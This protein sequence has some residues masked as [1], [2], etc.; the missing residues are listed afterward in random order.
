MGNTIDERVVSMRFDNQQFEKN[1]QISLGTLSKLKEA[2]RFDKIDMSGIS[3][4]IQAITDKVTGMGGIWD[5]A[6]NRISNKVVDTASQISR[7]FVFNPPTDGFKEYELKMNSLKVIMESSHE[8]LETVNKY[9]NEL[10]TYSDKTIYSFSDMTSSIGKFTNAGVDLDTAVKAIQ[11]IANEAALAGANTNEASRAMYNFAQALSAGSVKLIDWKSI[12]NANMA[13]KDFKE[14]LIK[15]A[16]ELGTLKKSGDDYIST[17]TN[18]QGKTSEAFNATKGFNDSLASQW[19]TTEVL[20]KTLGRYADEN[21]EI[22][23]RA[24]KAATEV[25]TFSAMMDALKEAVGSGW[26]QTWE[27]LFGNME[28]ATE[29]WTG[30]NDVLSDFIGK[31]SDARNNMLQGWKDMGGRA[32][33]IEGISNSFKILGNV[34]K[35]LKDAIT[36][37]FPPVTG[38]NLADISAKFA[39]FTAKVEKA[40]RFFPM[41]FFDDKTKEDSGLFG[42]AVDAVTSAAP[43]ATKAVDDTKKATKDLAKEVSNTS[44]ENSKSAEKT[45]KDFEK[46]REVV[47]GVVNGDYGN[48]SARVDALKKA[49]F[50]PEY[51]QKYV[52][53]LHELSGGTW[54]LSDKML[55]SVEKSIGGV[56]KTSEAT[57][58]AAD[59]VKKEL[60]EEE[61]AAQKYNE[62]LKASQKTVDEWIKK[63]GEINKE[64]NLLT[65]ILASAMSGVIEI[66]KSGAKIVGAFGAAWRDSFS[67]ITI[68]VESVQAVAKAF[69]DFSNKMKLSDSALQSFYNIFK[70]FFSVFKLVRDSVI[71]FAISALPTV[72]NV[73]SSIITTVSHIIQVGGTLLSVVVD[74][75]Q[76]TQ[77]IQTIVSALSAALRAVGNVIS[78]VAK[79]LDYFV[80]KIAAAI[81]FV[82][83]Y[84]RETGLLEAVGSRIAQIF[85]NIGNKFDELKGKLSEKLG[86]KNFDELKTKLDGIFDSIKNK[87]LPWFFKLTDALRDFSNGANPLA[88]LFGKKSDGAS[89]GTFFSADDFAKDKSVLE[90]AGDSIGYSIGVLKDTIKEKLHPNKDENG[91]VI[92]SLVPIDKERL[93]WYKALDFFAN[94]KTQLGN[95]LQSLHDI[96]VPGHRNEDG[97]FIRELVPIDKEK[98]ALGRVM[99]FLESAKATLTT[100]VSSLKEIIFGKRNEKGELIKNLFP[101]DKEG[102]ALQKVLGFL[103]KAAGLLS[104]GLGKAISGLTTIMSKFGEKQTSAFGKGMASAG[105]ALQ[106]FGQKF[107]GLKAPTADASSIADKLKTLFGILKDSVLPKVGGLFVGAA[108][109]IGNFIKSLNAQKVLSMAF[110]IKFLLGIIQG[111]KLKKALTGTITSIGGFFDGLSNALPGKKEE[112]KTTSMLKIAV[113]IA[114]VAKSISMIAD[115]PEDRLWSSVG[116]IAAIAAVLAGLSIALLK[117][118]AAEGSD[119][120]GAT[121]VIVAMGVAM[122]LIASSIA[123]IA[124]FKPQELEAA[125]FAVFMVIGTLTGAVAALNKVGK[126][127]PATVAGPIAF[128]IALKLL[129]KTISF[130]GK[131]P[132]DVFKKGEKNIRKIGLE[133]LIAM[134]VIGHGHYNAAAVA[135]P[136]AFALAVLALV[137]V[138]ALVG[139]IPV[140]LLIK[141]LIVV[142][143]LS[144]VLTSAMK[145]LKGIKDPGVAAAPLFLALGILALAF[146]VVKLGLVDTGAIIKGFIVVGLLGAMLVGFTKLINYAI[147]DGTIDKSIIITLIA[148]AGSILVLGLAMALLGKLELGQL[149]KGIV[150]VGLLGAII[151]AIM[152]FFATFSDG[153]H[154]DKSVV[155]AMIAVVGSILVLGITAVMLSLIP[156]PKLFKAVVAIGLLGAVL[157]ACMVF[158]SLFTD[159]SVIKPSVIVTLV[160][161]VISINTLAMQAAMLSLIPGPK[162]F[163]AVFAIGMLG[164]VIT[165]ALIFLSKFAANGIPKT[166]I[167]SMI[168]LVWSLTT[169]A[170][171]AALLG[172]VPLPMLA[173]GVAVVGLIGLILTVIMQQMSTM[174]SIN[175]AAVVAPLAIMAGIIGIANEIVILGFMPL[176][177]I[178]QGGL[179]V[180]GIGVV[181]AGIMLLMAKSAFTAYDVAAPIAVVASIMILANAIIS[182]G[183]VPLDIIKQGAAVVGGIGLLLALILAVMGGFDFDI[184]S[185]L[186]PL[187]VVAAV[188]VLVQAVKMLGEM[189]NSTAGVIGVIALL[190]A[191][192]IALAALSGLAGNILILAASFAVF[193]AGALMIGAA[194]NLIA[195]GVMKLVMAMSLLAMIPTQQLATNM[196]IMLPILA[197]VVAAFIGLAAAVI[198]LSPSLPILLGF[199]AAILMLGAGLYLAV[200]AIA[201]FV[202]IAGDIGGA[203]ANAAGSVAENAPQ[204]GA[205]IKDALGKA[206]GFIAANIGPFISKAGEL[207]KGM[208]KGIADHAPELGAKVKAGLADA[209][210]HIMEHAPEWLAKGKQLLGKLAEGI[211][212]NA[213]KVAAKVKEGLGKAGEY[214]AK[215]APKWLKSG[216]DLV[217]GLIKGLGQKVKDVPKAAK[218]LGKKALDAIKNFLGIKSPSKV[219]KEVG[220]NTGQGLIDGM[221]SKSGDVETKSTSWGEKIKSGISDALGGLGEKVASIFGDTKDTVESESSDLA[222][223]GS[224]S[225]TTY[226]DNVGSAME[227]AKTAAQNG[228]SAMVS[229]ISSTVSEWKSAGK[230]LADGLAN[231]LRT[232]ESKLKSSAKSISKKAADA[233]KSTKSKWHDVGEALGEGLGKGIKSKSS[234]VKGIAEDIIS[235][236][237]AAAKKKAQSHSPSKVWARLGADLDRGLIIGM[238]K[239]SPDVNRSATSVMADVIVAA[240][241][242]LDSLA[243]LMSSDIVDDPVIKPVMDLSEIQNSSNRLYSMI[244]DIDRFSLKGNID[245]A[246]NT[247]FSVTSD[248]NRRR[249]RENDILTTLIDGLKELRDQRNEAKGNTYIIDG[250]TYDDGSNVAAAIDMLVRA[251]KVGGRA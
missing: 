65:S 95:V 36:L 89:N 180:A 114:L 163:K 30:I 111:Y 216:K 241:G 22:G 50:D 12:E 67:G 71:S 122:F 115:I 165:A 68:S 66:V 194:F 4:N 195:D 175:P 13:T 105:N 177:V 57:S 85:T 130:L 29:F 8:S 51:I 133:L 233:V 212:A 197:L 125:G 47:K 138:V 87:T 211:A 207:I 74:F 49:G 119:I 69:G 96:F 39:D 88:S 116:V 187:A 146:A 55:S 199:S 189:E 179:V 217:A 44:K 37:V 176:D 155:A 229:A 2:L 218:D 204:I 100:A 20:T 243:D 164:A 62:G 91:N 10:N 121:G 106:G 108:K 110:A 94:V 240:K 150:A 185:L 198:L 181:L 225:M 219:F 123:K 144:K 251:A 90:E 234:Y 135:A 11:G 113:A 61:K 6:L 209:G 191:L 92:Q 83:T 160:F 101:L 128:A 223:A 145:Q 86:L 84:V 75:I 7:D 182:L 192:T 42:K 21:T 154:I 80:S 157:T 205:A 79:V 244:D 222:D 227:S 120:K 172:I 140:I 200:S 132:D 148:V 56:E 188:M 226:A 196:L 60:T 93:V 99:A 170:N 52:D 245:L 147:K 72:I 32:K 230:K 82:A 141:G 25:R 186:A 18:M 107:K 158:L 109:G 102:G 235:K 26:A 46:V 237:N 27:I 168:V 118:K 127:E 76:R 54:D 70:S 162:L 14:E 40:T 161:L 16:V 5:T 184:A 104:V 238:Q 35:P 208:A 139:F 190:G 34:L 126:L 231:G 214:I 248:T 124:K 210:K 98:T 152:F 242:P 166:V 73:I 149:L 250:I 213:P 178:I 236:A 23:A 232:S 63:T 202:T 224:E 97:E 239:L 220:E 43:K 173:K 103:N 15:T 3:K 41:K 167:L 193:A 64:G 9:L 249:S 129:A 221:D 45:V 137:G 143:A 156:G 117:I 1:V 136:I 153:M 171:E 134:A 169:L 183:L 228:L 203:I 174:G 38:K 19:M 215:E 53:K 131:I 77:I 31:F 206:A 24:S 81:N 17:T 247:S 112:S 159:N 33:L 201:T 58:K 151:T 142:K 48:D 28:E 246:E 59:K 78:F